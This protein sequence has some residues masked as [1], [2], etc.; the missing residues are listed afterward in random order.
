VTT[1][2]PTGG[3]KEAEI[4]TAQAGTAMCAGCSARWG[5]LKTAHCVACHATFSVVAAFDKH[6]TGSHA[7]GYRHCLDPETVGLVDVGR[8]YPCWSFPGRYDHQAFHAEV[9]M[10]S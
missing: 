6:R 3:E 2:S 9:V 5:G 4:R 7:Y 10:P 8:A 1:Q